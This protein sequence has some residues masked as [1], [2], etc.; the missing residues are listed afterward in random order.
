LQQLCRNCVYICRCDGGSVLWVRANPFPSQHLVSII[1]HICDR[2]YIRY[3]TIVWVPTTANNVR[4]LYVKGMTTPTMLPPFS[5]SDTVTV[6]FPPPNLACHGVAR[7]IIDVWRMHKQ[8]I[9]TIVIVL[10]VTKMMIKMIIVGPMMNNKCPSSI[11]LMT[12]YFTTQTDATHLHRLIKQTSNHQLQLEYGRV[13]CPISLDQ[14]AWRTHHYCPTHFSVKFP[15]AATVAIDL[16]NYILF[17]VI[18]CLALVSEGS[19]YSC[20]Y[21]V[22]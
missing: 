15:R 18:F 12:D 11:I 19:M 9:V 22:Y 2:H 1:D 17:N 21:V 13:E 5:S 3:A 7:W 14:L 8:V 6:A 20:N 10:K 16:N 4:H